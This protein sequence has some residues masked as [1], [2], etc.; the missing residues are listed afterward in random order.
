MAA[1]RRVAG[2]ASLYGDMMRSIDGGH[3]W[4][5]WLRML[6]LPLI[7]T[8]T[9]LYAGAI[10]QFYQLSRT[11]EEA[12]ERHHSDAMIARVLALG[13]RVT[14]GYEADLQQLFGRDTWRETCARKSTTATKTYC[15]VLQNA[16]PVE[17]VAASFILYGAL[18]VGGGKSTQRKVKKVFPACDHALFDV[19]EDMPKA[20]RDFRELFA[21]I[22]VDF[23]DRKDALTTQASRFMMLN[24]TVVSSVRCLPFWWWQA[25]AAAAAV[26]ALA[27]AI[28]RRSITAVG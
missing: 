22:G 23:P 10:A 28:K 27:M 7:L 18:V 4:G 6:K 26:T 13:L 19:A 3:T 14:P 8:D 21:T 25:A 12:L 11:L 1:R 15:N 20:R 24:N 16:D 9:Q 5:N 2:D 17:L